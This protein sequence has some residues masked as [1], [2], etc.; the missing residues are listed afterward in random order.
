MYDRELLVNGSSK[1]HKTSSKTKLMILISMAYRGMTEP[2]HIW[3]T[4]HG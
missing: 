3:F 2:V 4:L 1:S